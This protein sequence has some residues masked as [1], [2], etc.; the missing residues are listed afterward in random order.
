MKKLFILFV[1]IL[2]FLS[3]RGLSVNN[4]VV[5]IGNQGSGKSTILNSIIGE[6]VAKAGLGQKGITQ[7]FQKVRYGQLTFVDTPGLA[8]VFS[9]DQTALEIEKSL[10]LNG[11]Y[12]IIFVVNLRSGRIIEEDFETINRVMASIKSDNKNYNVMINK[13]S[14]I[15]RRKI[16]G[17]D[18][19]L[20][21]MSLWGEEL[22]FQPS[23]IALIDFD[24]EVEDGKRDFLI[25]EPNVLQFIFEKASQ[26]YLDSNK[27]ERVLTKAES[28]ERT[29]KAREEEA[30]LK[31]RI[32]Q[33][34]IRENEI[35]GEIRQVR[36]E[37]AEYEV[38]RDFC[39]IF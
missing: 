28:N 10:K 18:E 17:N 8:N 25:L 15:E 26:C 21:L 11:Y 4:Y 39:V 33:Q 23:N 14:K 37:C 34:K 16:F 9:P 38:D 35:R 1:L 29:R 22:D 31:R 5:L 7:N 36:G 3:V 19:F 12:S 32:E 13:I 27:V 20:T 2:S 24:N 6:K 30:A